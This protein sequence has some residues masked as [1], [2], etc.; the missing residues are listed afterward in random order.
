MTEENVTARKCPKDGTVTQPLGRRSGTWRCPDRSRHLLDTGA[1]RQGRLP[2][3]APVVTRIAMS[4][5]AIFVARRLRRSPAR[6][7]SS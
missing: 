2:W 7:S 4:L 1:R 5:L 6:Q 3:W